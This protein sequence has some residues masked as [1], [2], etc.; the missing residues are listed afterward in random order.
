MMSAARNMRMIWA[1]GPILLMGNEAY[2]M[3]RPTRLDDGLVR[4][5]VGFIEA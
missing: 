3:R 5:A 1:K 2:R 4:C